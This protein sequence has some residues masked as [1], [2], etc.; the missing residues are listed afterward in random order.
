MDPVG[1]GTANACAGCA[2]FL[3]FHDERLIEVGTVV[4]WIGATILPSAN[5]GFF[6]GVSDMVGATFARDFRVNGPLSHFFQQ[7]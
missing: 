5:L 1:V 3:E 6:D 7:T 4:W 2:S